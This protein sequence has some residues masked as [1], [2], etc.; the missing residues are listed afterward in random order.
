[1][2]SA[3]MLNLKFYETFKFLFDHFCLDFLTNKVSLFQHE[4]LEKTVKSVIQHKKLFLC[5]HTF[6]KTHE[7][8]NPSMPLAIN[9]TW[10]PLSG[11]IP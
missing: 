5:F 9:R 4:M 10:R 11:K 1:M 8:I 2:P 7:A 3:E 6:M